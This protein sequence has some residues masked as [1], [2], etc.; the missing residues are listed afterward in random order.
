M[1]TPEVIQFL[2]FALTNAPKRLGWSSK[3]VLSPFTY[4]LYFVST[5][6]LVSLLPSAKFSAS[7]RSPALLAMRRN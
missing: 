7:F 4:S 5:S 3:E 1:G 2:V 6:L